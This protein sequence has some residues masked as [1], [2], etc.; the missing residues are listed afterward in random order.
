MKLIAIIL[1]SISLRIYV[2]FGGYSG[3]NDPPQYGDFEAQRHW[4][5]LTTHLNVTQW[6][7][8]SEFNDPKWWPLDYPPLSGYFAYAL[9][10]VAEI[11]DP[12]IIAPYSSRGIET[13][14]TKLF[15][16]I[17]VFISEIIFLYPPLIY[18]IL[19][20]QSKQQLI[21]LCCPLLILVDHG[22]F[23]YNCIM[24]GLTLY[25]IINLE[26]G[27]LVLGSIFYVMALH[28]KVMSLYY[29][30]P[31]F[32]YI[33]SKTYKEPKKVVVVGIT[34][35]LTTLIIWL[36]WLSDLKL[37]Q[38]AIAT[39]FPIH[40]GLYQLHVATFWCISHVVIK[41][42]LMFNNQ[43]LFRLAAILTL[44][45]S[46]P[47]LI[48]LF[49]QPN[50]F[51][52]TLFI[53][54]QT[55][56]L[57]SFHVHEKTILLP[58]IL[59][60]ISQKDYGYLVYDYTIIATITHHPLMIEDKLFIEY[61]VL[62]VLF[63]IFTRN[64]QLPQFQDSWILRLYSKIRNIPVLLYVILF[65][66]QQLINPPQRFPFLYELSM[67]VLGFSMYTF[68]YIISHQQI[69]SVKND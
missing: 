49:K 57:F 54:S 21:A 32:I 4:M 47:S 52:H 68:M 66:C 39:I 31:F 19:K 8:K 69:K 24:L 33:L 40:R 37:I 53:V 48:R 38:E 22:H 15:M 27:K 20:Q 16:R 34:V 36:P 14:N 58:I 12:E 44:L 61:C 17:S 46:I 55:F 7:E 67:Q 25:A 62:L 1:I 30:L 60:L 6:Y 35:I 28:F 2:A 11:F 41:W 63:F 18:F 50:L 56:F 43:L 10:K 64:N 3:M 45:F 9:G 29:S 59:L 5:E 65:V 42:N 26:K 13:F 23:Q 51:R